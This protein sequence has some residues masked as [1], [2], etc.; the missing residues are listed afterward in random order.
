MSEADA[1]E[2]LFWHVDE[3]NAVGVD[4]LANLPESFVES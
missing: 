2:H 1:A 4:A 3:P